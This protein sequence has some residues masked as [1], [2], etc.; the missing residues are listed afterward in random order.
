[1]KDFKSTSQNYRLFLTQVAS[2]TLHLANTDLDT[3]QPTRAGEYALADKTYAKLLNKLA[4]QHF[5]NLSPKLRTH[6]LSFYSDTSAP[7]ATKRDP[8]E[9][10]KVLAKL[11]DL[12]AAPVQPSQ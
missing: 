7:I 9:W 11:N 10:Q 6:I 3:G 5:S 12:T 1:V 2:G 4:D 8:K